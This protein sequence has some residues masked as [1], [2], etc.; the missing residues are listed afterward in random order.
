MKILFINE[1]CGITSTGRITCELADKLTAQGH[2]CKIAY[3]RKGQVPARWQHYGVR[4]GNDWD[5]RRHALQTRLFD[6]CGFGSAAPTHKFLAWADAF[7]PDLVWIHNL[8]GYYIQV[9]LL[10]AWLKSRPQMQKKWT[11][12]DCWA[13]TGH[14]THFTAVGCRQWQ[15]GC[16]QCPQLDQYPKCSGHSNVARNYARKKA[17]FTG[18]QNMT[19]LTPSRWLAGLVGQSFLREY[20][21]TVAYNTLDPTIFKPTPSDFRRQYGLQGKTIV[22]GVANVWG[23]RKG[24]GDF[25]RLAQQLGEDV[26]IVLVGVNEKQQKQLPPQI[27]ALPKTANA[28]ELAKIYTA[29]DVFFNP[30]Y[31]DTYPTVNLEA[32]ACG[33]RVITYATGGAPETIHRP[34]SVLVQPGDLAQVAACIRG[35]Q[36]AP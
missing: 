24:L 22:L 7:D 23:E 1:V 28:G 5:V 33:T 21:V 18:V 10:F 14:C 32:E 3:G 8:H 6:Q 9:E 15:T 19:I 29:A 35:G 2:E 13:F 4:I 20:P 36:A 31:E 17:A 34:D 16:R 11:L 27:L 12:H 30:T 26:R 25:V